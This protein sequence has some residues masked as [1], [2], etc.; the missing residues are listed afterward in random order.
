MEETNENVVMNNLICVQCNRISQIYAT[1]EYVYDC[2]NALITRMGS[3]T[4]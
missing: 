4:W 1:R 3:Y 2:R